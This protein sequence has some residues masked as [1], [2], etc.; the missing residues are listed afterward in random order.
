MW[1]KGKSVDL[2]QAQWLYKM[3]YYSGSVRK[4]NGAG[5]KL[6]FCEYVD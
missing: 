6:G 1:K 3:E 4:K 5:K 2:I